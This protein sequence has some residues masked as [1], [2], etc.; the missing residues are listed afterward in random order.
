MA[1]TKSAGGDDEVKKPA[2]AA[3][4]QFSTL[5]SERR[6]LLQFLPNPLLDS[7]Y[8]SNGSGYY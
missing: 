2:A 1:E 3:A 4:V 6:H 8:S 5:L 7:L